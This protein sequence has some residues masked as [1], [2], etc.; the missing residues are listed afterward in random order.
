MHA[1]VTRG[2]FTGALL[3]P[4]RH[5]DGC[6]VVSKTRFERDYI[7]VTSEAEIIEWLRRGYRLRMSNPAVGAPSLIAPESI[8]FAGGSNPSEASGSPWKLA[9]PAVFALLAC[10]ALILLR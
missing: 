1:K 3:T 5:A 8:V 10:G 2:K 7:R 9:L 6:Y 4:H